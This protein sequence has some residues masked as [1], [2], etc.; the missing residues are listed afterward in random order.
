MTSVERLAR[1]AVPTGRTMRRRYPTF[2]DGPS[3]PVEPTHGLTYMSR[4]RLTMHCPHSE[5]SVPGGRSTWPNSPE[6]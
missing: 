2:G 6:S 1:L 5:H 4:D 3:C